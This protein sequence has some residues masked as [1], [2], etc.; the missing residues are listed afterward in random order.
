MR[1]MKPIQSTKWIA[2]LALATAAAAAQDS[3]VIRRELKAGTTET[4]KIENEIKQFVDIPN[5][6]EQDMII[7]Q[8]ATVAVKTM[9][10][11]S[12][13]GTADIETLTKIEKA[14][15]EGSLASMA[16]GGGDGKLPDP[17]AEKGTLDARN[18]VLIAADPKAK[19]DTGTGPSMGIPGMGSMGAQI[20]LNLIELPE[21]AMKIGDSMQVAMP[22]AAGMATMGIKDLKM[23]LKLVGER[24]VEGQKLWVIAFSGDMK[25]ERDPSKNTTGQ[26]DQGPMG[27]MKMS[28]KAQIS[29]EGLVDKATGKTVSNLMTI[30]NDAKMIVEQ[31]GGMEI[32]IKGTI[33]LKLSMVK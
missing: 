6:G 25:L 8:I 7:T 20:L 31:A 3:I 33:T 27:S 16:G 24:E 32:P 9:K 17:K 14:S 15:F 21:K 10:V 19:P 5:M 12:E 11:N 23:T 26:Q 28:G 4:Y 13:K 29:G 22:G 1:N 18:R 30:K 2:L